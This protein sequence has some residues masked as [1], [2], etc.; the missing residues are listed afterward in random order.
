MLVLRVNLNI[1]ISSSHIFSLLVSMDECNF[2]II[3]ARYSGLQGDHSISVKT[4][5]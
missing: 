5:M 1:A 4:C 3:S 2:R